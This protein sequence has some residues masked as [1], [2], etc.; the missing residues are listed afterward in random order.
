M[1]QILQRQGR[2]S[3]YILKKIGIEYQM[4]TGKA[5]GK[6]DRGRQR[7]KPLGWISKCLDRRGVDII[8][9]VEN[10][11]LYH[12]VAAS[13]CQNLTRHHTTT[14]EIIRYE[15]TSLRSSFSSATLLVRS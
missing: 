7:Q 15:R 8:R 11:A 12:A 3:G 5:E 14:N 2:F 6:T 13:Q 4:V 1:R 10:K 9:L